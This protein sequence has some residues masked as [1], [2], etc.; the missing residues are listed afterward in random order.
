M[1]SVLCKVWRKLS[2][3]LR[4]DW[5]HVNRTH[6][7]STCCSPGLR[8]LVHRIY[9]RNNFHTRKTPCQKH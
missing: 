7:W 8:V 3:G 2:C 6:F 9:F 5:C 1:Q 4:S